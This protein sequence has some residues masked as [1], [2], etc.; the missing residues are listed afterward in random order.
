VFCEIVGF[1]SLLLL[2]EFGFI[3][4]K[5]FRFCMKVFVESVHRAA[6]LCCDLTLGHSDFT[7]VQ[8]IIIKNLGHDSH[9]MFILL[10]IPAL[11]LDAC[12]GFILVYVSTVKLELFILICD[13]WK[14][15]FEVGDHE[16]HDSIWKGAFNVEDGFVGDLFFLPIH[17]LIYFIGCF[18]SPRIIASPIPA[19]SLNDDSRMSFSSVN[20][21]DSE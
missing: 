16:V 5:V 11:N 9:E 10:F 15:K 14:D 4:F 18:V 6:E 19:L 2:S 20:N 3:A 12:L 1:Q 13:F 17:A 8:F 7:D 21:N